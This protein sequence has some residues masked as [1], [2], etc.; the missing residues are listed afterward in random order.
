MSVE[1]IAPSKALTGKL[2]LNY[3][4]DDFAQA[5]QSASNLRTHAFVIGDFGLLLPPD[6]VAEVSESLDTCRLPNT[7]AYLRGMANLRGNMVP[8]FDMFKLL[9]VATDSKAY[10]HQL[11]IKLDEEWVGMSIAQLPSRIV[12]TEEMKLTHIPGLPALLQPWV[13]H[14]YHNHGI[15][16]EWDIRSFFA[17]MSGRI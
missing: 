14:C 10:R 5:S 11:F 6:S 1:L 4:S 12:L 13:K 8:V 15:W 17:S 16:I 3:A 7:S 2:E 9:D